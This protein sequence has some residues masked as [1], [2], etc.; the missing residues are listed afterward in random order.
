M[1][2]A[3]QR[4]VA[5]LARVEAF[6]QGATQEAEQLRRSAEEAYSNGQID[7]LQWSLLTGQSIALSMEYLDALRALGRAAIELNAFNQQ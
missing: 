5:Q 7:R 1:Q 3:H 2:Q 6:E 4:Y